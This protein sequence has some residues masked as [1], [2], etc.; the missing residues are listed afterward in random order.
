MTE[1]SSGGIAYDDHGDGDVAFLFLP[2]WCGPR[3]I[4]QPVI[5]RL[6]ADHRTLT[7]DWRG[8]GESKPASSDFGTAELVEDALSVI[9]E[10]GARTVV[11]VAA[12]HS[13]WIAIE[14]RRRLG[15]DRVP[16]LVFLDW[17]VLGAPAPFLGALAGMANP[18]STRAVVDQLFGMWLGHL[19]IPALTAY[20]A[21]MAAYPDEMWARAGR[22]IAAQ[23][24]RFG[25]P[26][27]TV[28]AL[29]PTPQTLHI[30]AQPADP[31]FLDAQRQLAAAKPWFQVQKLDALSNFP[32]FETPDAIADHLR[33]FATSLA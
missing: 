16:G 5:D 19:E 10:S 28:A 21:S 30:Y 12:A 32:I 31:G 17:M 6:G 27:D 25:T 13:G 2:G 14:L 3:T 11:P 23:F 15:A 29:D 4:F 1:F 18:A 33:H 22:E 24:N 26:L 7:L 8:H 20:V 9:E